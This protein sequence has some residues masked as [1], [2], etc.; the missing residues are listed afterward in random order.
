VETTVRMVSLELVEAAVVVGGL[1]GVSRLLHAF[2]RHRTRL[3]VERERSVRTAARARGLV[4]LAGRG[5]AV[6]VDEQDADGRR[7]LR[8]GAGDSRGEAA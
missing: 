8:I 5:G 4:R 7:V 6:V 2:I 1:L 3:R